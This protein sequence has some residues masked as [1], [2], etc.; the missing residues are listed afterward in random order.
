M[1][2]CS[3]AE[4]PVARERLKMIESDGAWTVSFVMV[5]E[6]VRVVVFPRGSITAVLRIAKVL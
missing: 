1:N 3:A 4:L 2:H 5:M 6:V